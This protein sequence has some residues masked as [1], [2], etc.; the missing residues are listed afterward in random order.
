MEFTNTRLN[1][2]LMVA[3]RA[4]PATS[5]DPVTGK[6]D[7]V[8]QHLLDMIEDGLG[9]HDKL[10][11]ER[12]LADEL[13]V[14]RLTVRRALSE[15]TVQNL[16][17][18]IQGSGTF[19]RPSRIAKS[20][21]LTSFSEDMRSR[22]LVPG[23]VA[24]EIAEEPAGAQLAAVLELSPGTLV[25][26][27]RR[28]RTADGTR[29]CLEQLQLPTHFVPGLTSQDLTGSLYELLAARY[30]IVIDRADQSIRATVLDPEDAARLGVPAY[31]PA[32]E[33]KRIA[34][35][36][37]GRPVERAVSRYRGDRYS[38]DFTVQVFPTGAPRGTA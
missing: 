36:N 1:E 22:G 19:V 26:S 5:P 9:P 6:S 17:Y 12:Q 21:E 24:I 23:S 28:V 20:I 8:R 3:S 31:S 4:A 16:V 30:G 32:F 10:P 27:V 2:E 13:G 38:Y 18:R 7:R 25:T 33:V 35:D 11:T 34:I 29:M 15:L 14:S 37:R